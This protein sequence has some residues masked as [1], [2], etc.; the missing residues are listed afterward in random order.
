MKFGN[1]LF[2]LEMLNK[3]ASS[4][5]V[6]GFTVLTILLSLTFMFEGVSESLSNPKII[7]INWKFFFFVREMFTKHISLKKAWGFIVPTVLLT[8]L[9]MFKDASAP[10]AHVMLQT[11]DRGCK[12]E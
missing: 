8:L 3:R 10:L 5:T 7:N 4:W 1:P 2:L 6:L 12:S 11:D 9:I